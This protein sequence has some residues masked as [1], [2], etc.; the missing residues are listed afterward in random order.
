MPS[1]L[2]ERYVNNALG[3]S[4]AYPSAWTIDEQVPSVS[5]EHASGA[6]V[7]VSAE[8]VQDITLEEYLA[9][10][11]EEL[12]LQLPLWEER[13]RTAIEVPSGFLVEGRTVVDGVL[14]RVK[15]FITLN[16]GYGIIAGFFVRES[17]MDTQGPTLDR[18]L[19][20]FHTFPPSGASVDDHGSV[21]G[22]QTLI[23]VGE[24]AHG[25]IERPGDVDLFSFAGDA[26]EGYQAVVA[27]GSLPGARLTLAVYGENEQAFC[28]LT[29]VGNDALAPGSRIQWT[30]PI[31]TTYYLS[32]ENG[33]SQGTGDYTL[34]LIATQGLP[35]DDYGNAPCSATPVELGRA[36]EG[37]IE[38]GTDVD[39]F[40]F[41]AVAGRTYMIEVSL[42]SLLDSRLALIDAAGTTLA[43][44]DNS[45]GA[46]TAKMEW[47]ATESD[48]FFVVVGG[49]Q[50]VSIG[51]YSLML[52]F[53]RST[54]APRG[55][56]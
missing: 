31:A 5:I 29:W 42:D 23:E 10:A 28:T 22:R 27:L 55:V 11:M 41:A 6:H 38:R 33:I 44:K 30:S 26:R 34:T 50:Q 16:K 52:T 24:V 32:V 20:A 54:R 4:L 53:E 47:T 3:Y 51:S 14:V 13:D 2:T 46:L 43:E 49:A 19:A 8:L 48:T 1:S 56:P 12:T 37:L 25:V 39:L 15:W 35:S 21:V 45:E 9:A 36:T 40:S 17:V 18:M 7:T